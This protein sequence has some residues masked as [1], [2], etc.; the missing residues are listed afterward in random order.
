MENRALIADF[1]EW[2]AAEPR[3]YRTVI[4]TWGTHCPRLTIWED[5]VE[6][7][8]VVRESA[9]ARG[10]LI[11]VTAAGEGFLAARRKGA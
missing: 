1:V 2:V 7:G 4:D 3:P 11:K 6:Q 5:A 9:G 10:T 8:L